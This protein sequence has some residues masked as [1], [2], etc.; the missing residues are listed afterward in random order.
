M[1]AY[2]EGYESSALLRD[3]TSVFVRPIRPADGD[4]L[5]DLHGRLSK[6]TV[7]LRFFAPLPRLEG[8]QLHRLLDVDYADRFALLVFQE[9]RLIG[10]G[11]YARVAATDEAE[12]AFAVDDEH[13]GHGVGTML[14]G[15]LAGIAREHG[16]RGLVAEVLPENEKMLR[17][18][19]E[20]GLPTTSRTAGG[21]V[22]VSMALAPRRTGGR[23]T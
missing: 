16:V 15:R 18:L 2:P 10:V 9:D 8:E 6:K 12:V 23:E 3:G 17:L 13:Q 21:T 5:V 19:A 4:L 7:Y 1:A 22:H 14:L 11:R 20:S